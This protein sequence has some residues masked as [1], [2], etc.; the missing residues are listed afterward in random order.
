MFIHEFHFFLPRSGFVQ[1]GAAADVDIR[2][3]LSLAS[4]RAAEFGR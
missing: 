2:W 4:F 3:R 1:Q